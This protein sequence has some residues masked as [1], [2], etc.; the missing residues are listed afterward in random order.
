MRSLKCGA[1][2]CISQLVRAALRLSRV[3]Q[4]LQQPVIKE[5]GNQ[6][7]QNQF[8]EQQLR[9]VQHEL[10]KRRGVGHTRNDQCDD[11]GPTGAPGRF[12]RTL[13]VDRPRNTFRKH[14]QNDH[15][16]EGDAPD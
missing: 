6:Y 14:R 11:D 3:L 1:T 12:P 15:G 8:G 10:T 7:D 9:K 4:V 13:F 16:K 5:F 2:R